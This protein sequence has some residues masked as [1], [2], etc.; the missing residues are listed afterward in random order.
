M[1][2]DVRTAGLAEAS[3]WVGWCCSYCAAPLAAHGHGL[4]CR[5]EGRWFATQ[6]GVHRLLPEERRRELRPVV[7]MHQRVRRDEGWRAEPGLPE[8]APAHPQARGWRARDAGFRQA[9]ALAAARLGPG[10]WRVL[11]VGAG[12]CWAAIRLLED[13]HRVAAVDVNIDAE[14]GLRGAERVSPHAAALD[15]AEAE[16]D[17]LP[18]EPASFDLVLAAGSLH[19]APNLTRTLVELRRVTRR[20]GLLAVFGSPLYRRRQDGE[21]VVA[22]R[23]HAH[24]RRNSVPPD[25]EGQ[26]GYLVGDEL[27]TLFRTTGWSLEV[28]G[29]TGWARQGMRDVREILRHGR[30][31]ARFP[32][33]LARRDG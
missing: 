10:P 2:G 27:P 20:G 29:L 31:A 30:R 14:D 26:P 9:R 22:E 32:I 23:M 21:A 19:Y 25:R 33:L 13:G 28:H 4:L 5:A 18:V 15:R 12:C 7:E 6:D 24:C 16:M 3:S 8:V 17:A 11:D 1:S